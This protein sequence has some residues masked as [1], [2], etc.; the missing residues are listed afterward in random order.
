MSILIKILTLVRT[1]VDHSFRNDSEDATH[2]CQVSL[3]TVVSEQSLAIDELKDRTTI[4][5]HVHVHGSR[6]P[7]YDLWS[8]VSQVHTVLNLIIILESRTSEII[9]LCPRFVRLLKNDGRGTQ[10]AIYDSTH[11]QELERD[12]DLNQHSGIERLI[13]TFTFVLFE[14]LLQ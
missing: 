9:Q 5:E 6:V 12:D 14:H 1:I 7:E 2:R 4:A 10:T 13:E 8:S 3:L 11:S